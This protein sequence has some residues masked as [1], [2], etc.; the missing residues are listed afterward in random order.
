MCRDLDQTAADNGSLLA[1]A[2]GPTYRDSANY[3]R[4]T[5]SMLTHFCGIKLKECSMSISA[6]LVTSLLDAIVRFVGFSQYPKAR[7][8][9]NL[10]FLLNKF[11]N[12]QR[13]SGEIRPAALNGRSANS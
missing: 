4:L 11:R 1:T 5:C 6:I 13:V 9:L 7:P 2:I 3:W 8:A 12:A 10:V